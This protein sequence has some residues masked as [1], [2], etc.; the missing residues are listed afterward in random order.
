[1]D[2]LYCRRIA[3]CDPAYVPRAACFDR[4]G[5]TPRCRRHWR[6]TCELCSRDWHYQALSHCPTEGALYCQ[7]CA[8]GERT[9]N[10][11]FWGFPDYRTRQCPFCADWHP[12]L[13]RWELEGGTWDNFVAAGPSSLPP[14]GGGSVY[15]A[16]GEA[17]S[18]TVAQLWNKNAALWDPAND[19]TRCITDPVLFELLGNVAG[20]VVVDAGCG[21]GY[22]ARALVNRGAIVIG[23]ENA[24][25]LLERAISH[26][27]ENPLGIRYLCGSM[28]RPFEV[29]DASV[30][31]VVANNVFMYLADLAGAL[32][33]FARLLKRGGAVVAVYSHP[34]FWGPGTRWQSI[35]PDSPRPEDAFS[36]RVAH[37]FDRRPH[38]F[39]YPGYPAPLVFFPRTLSDYIRHFSEAG[40]CLTRLEEPQPAKD[41]PFSVR[42]QFGSLPTSLA[43]RLE[44]ND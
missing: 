24:E 1:M 18:E 39:T 13:E 21:E 6:Y 5:E 2:C 27:Q 28:S 43:I 15:A 7:L 33:Q 4:G 34:C 16:V 23:F 40:F 31:L 30:D 10:E 12:T 41:M 3:Q 9:I 36:R 19:L 44:L 22:L 8:W 29:E 17:S 11:P 20:R 25:S 38:R 37:Y 42:A 14:E 32:R 35:P 26:E